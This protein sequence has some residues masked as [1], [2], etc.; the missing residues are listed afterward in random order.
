MISKKTSKN[1][2]T[3]PKRVVSQFPECEYFD[4]TAEEGRIVL[5]PVDPDALEKVQRKLKELGLRER[6]VEDAVA[7]ARER[8]R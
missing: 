8:A 7:W 4:V 5:R 2:I 3:L 6:D 1:Q